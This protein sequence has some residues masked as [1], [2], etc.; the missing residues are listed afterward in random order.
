[1]KDNNKQIDLIKEFCSQK[2]FIIDNKEYGV[3]TIDI[4]DVSELKKGKLNANII[5]R[6]ILPPSKIIIEKNVSPNYKL[7]GDKDE[8]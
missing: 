1:M 5:L 6:E 7:Y 2:I 4:E 8:D 3:E